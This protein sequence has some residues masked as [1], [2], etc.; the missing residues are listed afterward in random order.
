[1]AAR[2]DSWKVPIGVKPGGSWWDEKYYPRVPYAFNLLDNRP[3]SRCRVG[4]H[5]SLIFNPLT[6]LLAANCC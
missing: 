4:R 5:R 3:P 1:M 2:V 6:L